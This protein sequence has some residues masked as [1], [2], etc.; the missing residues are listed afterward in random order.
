MDFIDFLSFLKGI[1]EFLFSIHLTEISNEFLSGFL[2]SL[3]MSTKFQFL[4]KLNF[5]IDPT[6]ISICCMIKVLIKVI[7]YNVVIPTV[8]STYNLILLM[9][10]INHCQFQCSTYSS[11]H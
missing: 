4:I 2:L 6:K 3:T 9:N 5:V 11:V 10:M 7:E 8:H 1:E